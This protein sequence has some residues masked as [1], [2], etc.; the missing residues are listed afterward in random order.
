MKLHHN[1]RLFLALVVGD[2]LLVVR[3]ANKGQHRAVC[4]GGGLDDVRHVAFLGFLVEDGHVLATPGILRF[5]VFAFFHHQLIAFAHQ[6]AFHVRAQIKIAAMSDALQLAKLAF[7][8]KRKGILHIRRAHGVVAQLVGIVVAQ[9]QFRRIDAKIRVPLETPITPVSVPLGRFIGVTEKLHLHL[10]KFPRA[11][12][13][14]A[15]GDLVAETLALLRDAEGDFHAV[16]IHHV[17]EIHEHPLRRL[18]P[19]ERLVL[20]ITQRAHIR[21]EHQV[22]IARLSQSPQFLGVRPH[23]LTVIFNRG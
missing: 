7:L 9:N 10:L 1:A 11:E 13:E 3:V 23:H 15:R 5:A 21:F 6:L 20:L 4:T 8:A 16:A 19:Q 22:K 12:G 18:R 2:G 17:L 14:V